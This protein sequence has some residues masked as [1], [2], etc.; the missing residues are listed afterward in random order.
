MIIAWIQWEAL[1]LST[2]FWGHLFIW[3]A[4]LYVRTCFTLYTRNCNIKL[5]A[6]N[7]LLKSDLSP[8]TWKPCILYRITWIHLTYII[9]TNTSKMKKTS[10][11][12]LRVIPRDRDWYFK[13]SAATSLV[14]K[15]VSDHTRSCSCLASLEPAL[16][17]RHRYRS[18][19]ESLL[20]ATGS[21]K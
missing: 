17:C 13:T 14:F 2:L 19:G 6:W 16:W 5:Y 7:I 8:L 12:D 10:R 4:S 20:A 21:W 11:C 1:S 3:T 15:I 9:W 18:G